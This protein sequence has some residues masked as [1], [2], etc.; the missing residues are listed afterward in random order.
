MVDVLCMLKE[1]VVLGMGEQ[2]RARVLCMFEDQATANRMNVE[3]VI[4]NRAEFGLE[5]VV[6][7]GLVA[8]DVDLQLCWL[9]SSESIHRQR[10]QPQ[11]TDDLC[12]VRHGCRSHGH[13]VV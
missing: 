7:D 9:R 11:R 6:V 13:G 12:A 4:N 5:L 2:L 10:A 3:T 1:L 8:G